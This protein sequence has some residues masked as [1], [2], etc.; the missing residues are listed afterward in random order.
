MSDKNNTNLNSTNVDL[1]EFE[2]P[3]YEEWRKAAEDALKGAPFDKKLI[4]KTY[5]HIDLQPIYN[6]SDRDKVKYVA[7]SLPGSFPY[8]RGICSTGYK[9]ESWTI[10][11][12]TMYPTPELMNQALKEDLKRGQT[13]IC[14]SVCECRPMLQDICYNEHPEW[15][16]YV[17]PSTQICDIKDFE[18]LFDGIDIAK[19]PIN[20]LITCP[21]PCSFELATL[22]VAYCDKH[23]IDKKELNVNFGFEFFDMLIRMGCV[24]SKVETYLDDMAALMALCNIC[25]EKWSAVSIDGC[26]YHNSG[27]NALQEIAYSVAEGVFFI[28][29]MLN[30]GLKIDD[31][32]KNIHFNFCSGVRFFTEIAK[33]RAARIVW[34][35]IVKE[36]GGNECSQKMFIHAYT[37]K[38]DKTKF[39][40]YVNILRGTTE[41]LAAVLAGANSISIGTFDE[42]LG[43]A[44][45]FS[46]RVA[47]NVQCILK[48]EAHLLDT[49][50]PAGGSYYIETMTDAFATESWKIFREVEKNGG[51]LECV[52]KG[53]VQDEI[54]KIVAEREKNIAFRRDTILGTNKYPNLTEKP[55]EG[56]VV[57]GKEIPK[58]H[59]EAV[60]ARKKAFDATPVWA[61]KWTGRA[62]KFIAA[63][64]DGA[65]IAD[66]WLG[67][68]EEMDPK[69]TAAKS[70]PL[71]RSAAMFEGL[72]EAATRYKEISGKA[73]QI[74][75]ENFGTLKQ[76]KPRM[77]FSTDFFAVAGFEISYGNGFAN[78]DDAIAEI[79]N[80]TA[81][82]VVICSNDDTYPEVV[83]AY[84]KALK[85][86]KPN[87][88]VI[89]AGAQADDIT[90]TFKAAGVDDFIS[91]KSNVY[92]T[93]ERLFEYIG[94]IKKESSGCGCGC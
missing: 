14:I 45:E 56:L 67:K 78:A 82:V 43:L 1:S 73:P 76:Y 35:K 39:D 87:T 32:A 22:F 54:L 44:N 24:F 92:A 50:D 29:E 91:I 49:I 7:E 26:T 68:G 77:D 34:A 40:P 66:I 28:K 69:T 20:F 65:T 33:L 27:A 31:I 55:V 15:D 16:D 12:R 72:R 4:T 64:K 2:I 94:V 42:E 36:F 52:L 13:G 46:R 81:P 47:R 57:I 71:F 9:T 89:V 38:I 63:F 58:T 37:S 21:T 85:T 60:K 10:A 3:T 11:Q 62:D 70:L 79:N 51:I 41:G 53:S 88:K 59:L 5:E 23:N 80:I 90:A 18:D 75:F 83:P 74:Y 30:R 6:E 17:C 93:L 8:T 25:G 19:Y 84:V 61:E 86:A 48:E